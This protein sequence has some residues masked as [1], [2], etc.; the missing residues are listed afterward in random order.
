[1]S[2][3]RKPDSAGGPRQEA[4][5]RWDILNDRPLYDCRVWELRERR[6]RHPKTG[7]EGDFF[8]LDSADW[9]LVVARTRA[10]ELLLVRQFRW[11][12]DELSW[13]LPGGIIDSGEDPVVAGLRELREET[14]YVADSGRVIGHARPNPAILNNHCHIVFVDGADPHADGTA[15]DEHEEIEVRPLPQATVLEWVRA[16]RIGHALALNALL[17][18]LL[19]QETD[20][21]T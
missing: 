17:F 13:E 2:H 5:P 18:Y 19:D 4:P 3:S 11:G 21:K 8:Y 7:K 14:G 6:Y 10:G 12:A 9:V 1:M 20:L 16:C 15:W